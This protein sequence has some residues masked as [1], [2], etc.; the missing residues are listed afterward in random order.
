[1]GTVYQNKCSNRATENCRSIAELCSASKK[2]E[3]LISKQILEIE[4]TSGVD[5]TGDKQHGFKE[6]RSSSTLSI[7]LQSLK[8]RH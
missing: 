4:D 3:R 7:K 8:V 2:F 1:M 5:L 6:V